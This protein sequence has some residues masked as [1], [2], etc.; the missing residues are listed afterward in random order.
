MYSS[1]NIKASGR[2]YYNP[3][4]VWSFKQN[5]I[6]SEIYYMISL[7]FLVLYFDIFLE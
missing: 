6:D 5:L 2:K 1:L 3:V 4:V 7:I